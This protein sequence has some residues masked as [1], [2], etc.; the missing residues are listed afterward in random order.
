MSISHEELLKSALSLSE[1]DRIMLATELLDSIDSS[2]S[3]FSVGDPAFLQEL[4]KRANDPSPGIPWDE[5][6][7]RMESKLRR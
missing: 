2:P 7:R 1:A 6:K 5:V 3:H 4:E